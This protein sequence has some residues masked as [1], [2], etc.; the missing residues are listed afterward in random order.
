M[1]VKLKT[2]AKAK[3][4]LKSKVKVEA[5]LDST[6]SEVSGPPELVASPEVDA[7]SIIFTP[8]AGIMGRPPLAINLTLLQQCAM[9]GMTVSEAAAYLKLG[10]TTLYQYMRDYGPIK[11]AWVHGWHIGNARIKRAQFERAVTDKSDIM[12]KWLGIQRLGQ[13]DT[14]HVSVADMGID[15]QQM[16]QE[17]VELVWSNEFTRKLDDVGKYLD[18]LPPI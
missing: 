1:A 14:V 17:R 3:A 8:D 7:I 15:H 2:K 18:H 12:L 13:T 4:K 9:I 11:D 5:T 16:N 6:M 10:R